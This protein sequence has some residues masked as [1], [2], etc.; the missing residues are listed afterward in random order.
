MKLKWQDELHLYRNFKT[1]FVLEGN[2]YDNY[3]YLI[4]PQSKDSPIMYRNLERYLYNYYK[5]TL[6][7]DIVLFVNSIDGIYALKGGK[8]EDDFTKYSKLKKELIKADQQAE[9]DTFDDTPT[10]PTLFSKI[11]T[12]NELDFGGRKNLI[13]KF[14]PFIKLV[15]ENTKLSV[16]FIMTQAS[17]YTNQPDNLRN[18]EL[19]FFTELAMTTQKR[20]IPGTKDSNPN[21]NANNIVFITEKV[22]DVPFWF[23]FNNPYVKSVLIGLP[24]IEERKVYFDNEFENM[25]GHEAIKSDAEKEE[26]SQMFVGYTDGLKTIEIEALLKLLNQ[27]LIPIKKLPEAV[28]LF[29]YGIRKNPWD[30]ADLLN[31]IPTLDDDLKKKIFGQDEVINQAVDIVRRAVYGFSGIQSK[32]SSKPK[33]VMFL[34]GPTGTGKTEMAKMITEWLF[35]KPEALIRFDMSEYQQ[36]HSDQRLLGAPPGYVGYDEGGQLTNAI[37]AN[38]FSVILFDEIEKAHPQILDKFLQILDDGRMTDGKGETIYFTDTL[39]IFT[40]NL[41][42]KTLRRDENTGRVVAETTI[43]YNH[44]LTRSE[45]EKQMSN[46]IKNHFDTNIGRPEL[47]NRFGDNFLVFNYISV[48]AM[49]DILRQKLG[50]VKKSLLEDKKIS[51]SWADVVFD[52]LLNHAN[53]Y[54]DKGGRGIVTLVEKHFINPLVRLIAD[55]SINQKTHLDITIQDI[56]FTNIET[57]LKGIIK[58]TNT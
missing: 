3:P 46:A 9:K 11:M 22:N 50:T 17:R 30:A 18:E 48:E 37:K 13:E 36:E 33:G 35:A 31:R 23:Y 53:E 21:S 56:V 34:S 1:T 39:I 29:K 27:E 7:Y 32:R 51:L 45:F 40:S 52:K 4:E 49:R 15:Y 58:K 24:T 12:T 8:Q 57:S 28:S 19:S 10:R 26:I 43:H 42:I 6:K 38:P 55:Q 20:I 47:L 16:A 5:Y 54:R 41:G 44:T 14:T 25:H 2:I